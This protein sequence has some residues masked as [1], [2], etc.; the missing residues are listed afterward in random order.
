MRAQDALVPAI[1][2]LT[3]AG[4]ADAPGDA[5]KLLA[6]AMRLPPDRM[7]LHLSDVMTA[8]DQARFDDAVLRRSARQPVSQ[9]I[10]HRDF[11]GRTFRISEHVLDPR[12][13]TETLVLAALAQ[14]FDR[15]L[16]LGTGSGCILLSLLAEQPSAT[17]IGTDLSDW[18]LKVA[19]GN[20]HRMG[21]E[22]RASFCAG[23]WFAAVEGQGLFDLILSN[24]P[25]ISATEVERLEP[26]VRDWEPHLALTPGGD[27]LG[28]YRAIAAG[29]PAHL[30]PGGRL[31]V[32]TGP[33]QGPAVA[34]LW[35]D[36]GLVQV[37]ILPDLD[38]RDRVVTGRNL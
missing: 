13:E 32:E 9:I 37:Q 2:R 8:E 19:Q 38:G 15:V 26:E 30:A 31:M 6:H 35:H 21:L 22:P 12:P 10:G 33:T 4:V 11:F 23:F 34:Q 25:Y 27:G 28:A 14:P 24:P 3:K 17:G 16:D 20:C 7:T 5:R 1:R 29:A 18:A 36:A